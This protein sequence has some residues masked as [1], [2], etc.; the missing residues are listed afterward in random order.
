MKLVKLTTLVVALSLV[1]G[2]ALAQ[3]RGDRRGGQNGQGDRNGMGLMILNGESPLN[4]FLEA[5]NKL[6]LTTEQKA[7]IADLKKEYEP[8][9]K[10]LREKAEKILT[11]D[12]KKIVADARKNLKEAKGD[13]RRAAFQKFA[14]ALK[15]V[16]PT[17]E[18]KTKLRDVSKEARTLFEEARKKFTDVLTDAQKEELKKAMPQR[19]GR[20][21]RGG[22]GSPDGNGPKK[23]KES[24]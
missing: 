16:K 23:E 17:D 5:I 11:D 21:E 14:E 20:G 24:T 15:N 19:G 3:P 4:R 7:K 2:T 12:Q 1:A 13:D 10:A 18:Q 8:K 22:Q 6:D 9:G